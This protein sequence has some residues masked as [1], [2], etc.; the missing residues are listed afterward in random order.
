[1]ESSSLLLFKMLYRVFQSKDWCYYYKSN[2]AH[3]CR[4][5]FNNNF[6]S[7][8][9]ENVSVKQ[10]IAK[11]CRTWLYT[12]IEMKSSKSLSKR[13]KKTVRNTFCW[14]WSFVPKIT[15]HLKNGLNDLVLSELTGYTKPQ[16]INDRCGFITKKDSNYKFT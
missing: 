2:K 4:V 9:T 3:K 1:M 14:Q 5:V 8:N 16:K 12:N 13:F 10:D 11:L 7:V 6:F 15:L